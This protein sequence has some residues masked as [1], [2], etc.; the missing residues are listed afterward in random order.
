MRPDPVSVV[1][2]HGMLLSA[3]GVRALVRKIARILRAW[4][5]E[6]MIVVACSTELNKRFRRRGQISSFCLTLLTPVLRIAAF[7]PRILLAALLATL[8]VR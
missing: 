8:T 7:V 3:T 5:A 4:R 1:L 6:E 2:T